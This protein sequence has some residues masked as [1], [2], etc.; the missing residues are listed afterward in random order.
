MPELF[1]QCPERDDVSHSAERDL[2]MGHLL[3]GRCCGCC[4]ERHGNHWG[5]REGARGHA[6]NARSAG[7]RRW[8]EAEQ[9]GFF[10]LPWG[11]GAAASPSPLPAPDPACL[12]PLLPTSF[13]SLPTREQHLNSKGCSNPQTLFS[14]FF[15]LIIFFHYKTYKCP[16]SLVLLWQ[17]ASKSPSTL[18]SDAGP[19]QPR[20]RNTCSG[21]RS[22]D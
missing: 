12:D 19:A 20:I 1:S 2:H 17:A 18:K 21:D 16:P 15:F 7:P 8:H 6:R 22:P 14:V 5:G 11:L 3:R 10:S 9:G 13:H 4:Q